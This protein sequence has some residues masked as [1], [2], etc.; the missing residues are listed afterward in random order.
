MADRSDTFVSFDPEEMPL[1]EKLYHSHVREHDSAFL[2]KHTGIQDDEELRRH[3]MQIQADAYRVYPYPCIRYFWFI[4]T[5]ITLQPAYA[6]LLKLGQKRPGA[7]FLEIPCAFG[8]D[9]RKVIDGGF[10]QEN[11]VTADLEPSYWALGHRLFKSTPES[12]PV[13][14]VPGDIFDANYLASAPPFYAPLSTPAPALPSLITLTPL[15]GRVSAINAAMFFHLFDEAKQLALA[16][17]LASLLS[18]LPGTLIL[19]L[20]YSADVKGVRDSQPGGDDTPDVIRVFC[21]SPKSWAA[22]WDGGVFTKGTVKAEAELRDVP[23]YATAPPQGKLWLMV[24]S[25]TRL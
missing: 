8:N 24:W 15:Q 13:P 10:P 7:I 17:R 11:C 25:V 3:A 20:H 21:H 16:Q 5:D 4:H 18:P 14:F 9:I 22:L 12:F 6:Q 1:D 2:K 19:G 23:I